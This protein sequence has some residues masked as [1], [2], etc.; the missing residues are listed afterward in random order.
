MSYDLIQ[1]GDP[2]YFTDTSDEPYDRHR[3]KLVFKNRKA[4]EFDDWETARNYWFEW[5]GTSYLSHVEVLDKVVSK[6]EGFK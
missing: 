3:Y 1:P 4:I 2:M 5:A 6:P